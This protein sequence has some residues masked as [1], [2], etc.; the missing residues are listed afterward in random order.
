ME[1]PQQQAAVPTVGKPDLQRAPAPACKTDIGDLTLHKGL[2]AGPQGCQR[3]QPRAILIAI[4]EM[5]EEILDSPYPQLAQPF[6][7][8]RSDPFEGLHG[9][10]V[11]RWGR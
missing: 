11:K 3:D 6:G 4:G 9:D 1:E 10:V 8:A 5:E 2:V 7:H